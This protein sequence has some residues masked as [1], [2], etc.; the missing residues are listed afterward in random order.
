MGM[1]PKVS[2]YLNFVTPQQREEM[3]EYYTRV[4]YAGGISEVARHF[5]RHRDTIQRWR[6]R[7]KWDERYD[8]IKVKAQKK[9]DK[10][11]EARESENLRIVR[12][13]K[14]AVLKD[15]AAQLKTG[16]YEVT[17]TE[18]ISLIRLEIELSGELPVEN[19]DSII[20]IFNT[21][22]ALA[23]DQQREKVYGNL[24]KIFG[25]RDGSPGINIPGNRFVTSDN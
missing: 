12:S 22:P 8:K 21:I 19:G 2:K 24:A 5:K 7:D 25:A 10:A 17:V 1:M 15:L 16:K 18:L 13:V 14:G 9:L 6:V 11:V 3:F 20:N 23:N 4:R